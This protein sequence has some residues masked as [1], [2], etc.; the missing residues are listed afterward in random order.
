M[1]VVFKSIMLATLRVLIMKKKTLRQI[2]SINFD[3]VIPRC[4]PAQV[5]HLEW[6]AQ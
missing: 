3:Y 4:Q 6:F 5:I 2:Y 1:C